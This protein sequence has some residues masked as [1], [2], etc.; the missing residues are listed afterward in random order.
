MDRQ[1]ERQDNEQDRETE[2][3]RQ[4]QRVIVTENDRLTKR[5][6]R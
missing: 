1:R 6:T 5:K 2:R 4:S 3:D